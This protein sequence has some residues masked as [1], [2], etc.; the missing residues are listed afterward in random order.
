MRLTQIRVLPTDFARSFRFYHD[1]LGLELREGRE[2]GVYA[3]FASETAQVSL[4]ARGLMDAAV[5]GGV[6]AAGGA[7]LVFEV[8]SVDGT[9]SR[10]VAAGV[11]FEN[12][13]HDRPEWGIRVVHL[14]DPDGL[15]VELNEPLARERWTDELRASAEP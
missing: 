9:Y 14:R 2:E 12:E 3:S 7:V 1:V 6:A 8:A 11:A 10:L 15:L 5:P 13:P 4:F